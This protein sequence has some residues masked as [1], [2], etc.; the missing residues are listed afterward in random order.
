MH[1]LHSAIESTK[2]FGE[3]F[4]YNLGF[5]PADKLSWKPSPTAKSALEITAHQIFGM[6]AM[7]TA[8]TT[9][10]GAPMPVLDS[11]EDAQ[12]QIREATKTYAAWLESLS[13]ADL[14]GEI[15][16]PFGSFPRI[17]AALM[18][19]QDLVH[20]HGQICYIQT[21]LGDNE[22]HFLPLN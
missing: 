16:L 5:I 6:R 21:I 8:L 12:N 10:F 9:G 15:E 18:E 20:H 19:T 22:D 7:K 4:A 11:L 17:A 1:P 13:S 2:W 14:E 3:N